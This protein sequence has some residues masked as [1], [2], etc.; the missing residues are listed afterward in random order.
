MKII[1]PKKNSSDILLSAANQMAEVLLTID[2]NNELESSI[3]TSMEI[4]GRSMGVDRVH[5]W[6]LVEKDNAANF[7]HTRQWL[8]EIGKK[9]A[10]M[11]IGILVPYHAESEWGQALFH[12]NCVKGP[13]SKMPKE[14]QDLFTKYDTKS[15]VLVPLYLKEEFWGLFT[16]NDCV[17]ERDFNDDEI[18]ILQSVSLMMANAI[19]RCAMI[20]ELREAEELTKLMLDSS[21]LCCQIWDRNYKIID[22][23]EAG[24]KLYGFKNK[25]EFMDEFSIRCS[26]EFQPDG[27]RSVEGA[28]KCIDKAFEE[29]YYHFN[30]MHKMPYSDTLMPAEIT[31][32]LVS[33]KND[34]L[35]IAY[36]RDL[37]EH[38]KMMTDLE[39]ALF[40]A[41]ESSRSKSEFLS[42]M[43]HEM[44]TPMNAIKGMTQLAKLRHKDGELKESL[45]EIDYASNQLLR[46]INDLLDVSDRRDSAFLLSEASF[47]FE[48]MFKKIYDEISYNF[49]EKKQIFNYNI[50]ASIPAFLIGDERHLIRVITYLLTNANKFT[51]AYGKVYFEAD[52][53][54]EDNETITLRIVISDNGIGIDKEHQNSIFNIFEQVDGGHKRKHEGTGLGLPIARRIIEIMGGTIR[55]D[56]ELNK[57]AK[58]T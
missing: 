45:D 40:E 33:Y 3:M 29:G 18:T 7:I 17:Q 32:V 43:S 57:G 35:V 24:L 8:S 36:T 39:T 34:F 27:Q 5:I 54:S 55:V 41:R 11:P 53:H 50:A 38:H 52:I 46:L 48:A 10:P 13:V 44:L 22:C 14:E 26:P 23:N 51:P 1:K 31:L 12:G 15:V 49:S 9:K 19:N 58:F 47:S 2:D 37:R 16:I 4:I 6:R 28:I 56:S 20:T 25:Q 30:W 42:R 21:P